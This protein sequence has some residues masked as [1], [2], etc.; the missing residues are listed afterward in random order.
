MGDDA[1]TSKRTRSVWFGAEKDHS[2]LVP[3]LYLLANPGDDWDEAANTASKSISNL[4]V[5]SVR[6]KGR[7]PLAHA[8][9]GTERNANPGDGNMHNK[10]E[11]IE[12]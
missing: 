12:E 8:R 7:L 11:R 2:M 4:F 3:L 5:R 6:P 1:A 10:Q 9:L